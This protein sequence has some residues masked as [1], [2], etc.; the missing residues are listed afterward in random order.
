MHYRITAS[1][2][3]ALA[4][5]RPVAAALL[6]AL[7]ACSPANVDW[8][9]HGNGPEEQRFSRLDDINA[10]SVD[11][12]GLDWF[13]D[14][15]TDR[16]QEATPI[17]VGGKLYVSTAWSMV[18]AFDGRTGKLLWAYD[19]K[20][21]REWA[22][23][24]CCDVVNRGVAVSKGRVFVGTLDGRLVA[25]DAA[26]GRPVWSTLTIDPAKPYTITGAPRV[27]K[28]K[29]IIGNGG[30]EYG[31][32]GYVSAYDADT[33]K[34]AWRFYTVPGD[35]SKPFEMPILARAARTWAGTWWK[36]GGGGTVWDSMAYD[37]TL[38][39]LYIGTGN[40]SPWNRRIRSAGKGDNL[41]LSSIIALRPE[42]GAYVW[43]YQV[44]PGDEWD[45]TATQP[46]MLADLT[47]DGKPRKVLMQA[48]KNGFFY[49]LD[50]ATGKLLSAKAF[51]P[52]TWASGIDLKTGRPIENPAAR[53]SETGKPFLQ[54]PGPLGAHSWYPMSFNPG[55]GLVYLPTQTFPFLYAPDGEYRH[56]RRGW[57]LGAQMGTPALPDAHG[58]LAAIR[59]TIKG[60]LVAW[61]PVRQR[62]VWRVDYGEAFN[63]GTLA[64]AG[65]L[66]FQGN[67][68]G[69]F[70]A[71][72]ADDGR[73]M[74]SF[75]AQS[76]IMAAPVT[77]AVA[78]K[79]Y[80]AVMAGYGGVGGMG[81]GA[82]TNPD[83]SKRNISR[84]LVFSLEGKAHLPPAPPVA[85]L[86]S[87]APP[88]DLSANADLES[89]RRLYERS[90]G[91]CHGSAAISAGIAP[92]LRYSQ[93]LAKEAFHAVVLDGALRDAGMAGF[94][95]TLSAAE[96][97]N[98]RAYLVARAKLALALRRATHAAS[99]QGHAP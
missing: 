91:T 72:K 92:D 24:A 9:E 17:A 55:T 34:L 67:A 75:D 79:Q 86:P 12:L 87:P 4:A 15:D 90:C 33:G 26:T 99:P 43:H 42:T 51:A 25:L 22:V 1:R 11:R 27:V 96:V 21:P 44:T 70:V 10:E 93:M 23:N 61:D 18:K 89:G 41:F 37:P 47:F 84:L 14:L 62:E 29:V 59:S 2:R 58:A 28:G 46:I 38:D 78:G 16:G 53:Y 31:V 57:N 48:P 3:P 82:L 7:A 8:A 74:W 76:G 6:L 50:R 60:A 95:G 69:R 73:R 54:M 5:G 13:A 20:V 19:P 68:S 30:A 66:V 97:E 36:M 40:G 56:N 32:R 71:Y 45:F 35:P 85:A 39:L 64:T 81:P 83:R 77:Y 52:V 63:G 80:I 98:V 88:V 49:V 94:A 65:D